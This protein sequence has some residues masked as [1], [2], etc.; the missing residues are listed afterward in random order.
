[1]K[2]EEIPLEA[3]VL[4][5]EKLVEYLQKN[6]KLFEAEFTPRSHDFKSRLMDLKFVNQNK[7]PVVDDPQDNGADIPESFDGRKVW[8]NCTSLF[9]IRDQANCGAWRLLSYK[10]VSKVLWSGLAWK[11]N[12]TA[13][14]VHVGPSRRQLRCPIAYASTPKEKYRC[15]GGWPIEAWRY[16]SSAGIVTGGNYK[17]KG[18]CRPY[19]IHPCGHHGNE[20]Y[21]GE[22]P[23]N[24]PT[25]P[26]RK[27]CQA[28][29]RKSF[30]RDKY[31]VMEGGRV[32]L[33]M[34]KGG[35]SRRKTAHKA[36][37]AEGGH[38][39]KIIGWGTEN[40]VPY[41]II[42]NSWHDDWGEDGYFRFIRGINDCGIEEDVVAGL[43]QGQ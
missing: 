12:I 30:P 2:A 43:V 20:P 8:A 31:F 25:P 28:G 9:Y 26:C 36:G 29:Y 16:F 11:T 34:K 6:Q 37:R 32:S 38:A 19:E 27:R 33:A 42:A 41:W 14:Q 18:C 23:D 15:D 24:A 3:Q 4:T 5:G 17:S 39:V 13:L 22:C 7:N 1:L 40:D 21:Y 35:A 10:Y